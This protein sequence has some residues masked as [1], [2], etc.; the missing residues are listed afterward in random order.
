MRTG[1]RPLLAA[2]LLS[3]ALAAPV[4]SGASLGWMKGQAAQFFTDT[5]WKLLDET[6]NAALD[7]A[8]DGEAREWR[9][10]KSRASGR[11]TPLAS[12]TRDD[13]TC[14]RVRIE[15]SAAGVES[16]YR[17]LFCRR[18]DGPWGIGMPKD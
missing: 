6:L 4:A 8:P 11:I 1:T 14:R 17:Y 16:S 15:S 2:L 3:S 13:V 12:H 18:A 7:E 9:N 5:D 10:D